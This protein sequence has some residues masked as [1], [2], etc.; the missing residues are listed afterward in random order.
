[1]R[2][3]P[4]GA[5]E[6]DRDGDLQGEIS[7]VS[8]QNVV[9]CILSIFGY[10]QRIRELNWKHSTYN[11]SS[12]VKCACRLIIRPADVVHKL[13]FSPL[14]RA[15]PGWA[16]QI[17]AFAIPSVCRGQ[18]LAARQ[19]HLV[20]LQG[21]SLCTRASASSPSQNPI[22]ILSRLTRLPSL[23]CLNFPNSKARA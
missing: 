9:L 7:Y 2:C 21:L 6:D 12:R 19:A 14:E 8:I 10:F 17:L 23:R 11:Y 1:M 20:A 16:V 13:D 22:P 18:A 3:D 15:R 4:W 5:A